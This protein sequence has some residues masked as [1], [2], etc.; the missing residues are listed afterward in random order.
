MRCACRQFAGLSTASL[1]S[2]REGFLKL[3]RILKRLAREVD[4]ISFGAP[5]THVYNPLDYAWAAHK[6]YL[7]RYG[8][9]GKEV[10][11]VGM[12]PG[13]FGMAQTGVPF[14]EVSL[15]RDWLGIHEKIERPKI[16]HPKRP[17]LGFDCKR[18][19]VSGR[20]VWTW[21]RDQAGT[22][23]NFFS[24]FF[25]YNYCPLVFMEETGRNRTPDKLAADEREALYEVCDRALLAVITHLAPR[26]V[27]GVG[28]FA[29]ARARAALESL[30]V[31]IGRVLHPSPASPMANRG[32]A[33]QADR[34]LAALG[35]EP[36]RA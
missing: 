33:E 27:V 5:V 18:S 10:V 7:D 30:D 1:R 12:N 22:P 25:I 24:R 31:P 21:A 13:P 19:E 36:L 32:W 8:A 2:V 11:L 29:E 34:Q 9:S 26:V 3:V 35:I 15:V 20:R 28:A 23:E 14:G 16:E 4:V 6:Q 17:I